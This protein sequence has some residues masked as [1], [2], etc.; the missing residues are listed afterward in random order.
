MRQILLVQVR[1]ATDPMID[2]EVS[3]I[4]RRFG[5]RAYHLNVR[6]AVVDAAKP[7]WL[8]GMDGLV[9]GGSGDFSVHH[10][11]SQRWVPA[12]RSVIERALERS[13]PGFGICFGHQLLGRHLGSEVRTEKSTS[14]MGTVMV[15]LTDSGRKSP[16][17]A[18]LSSPFPVHCG[19]SDYVVDVP[20]GVELLATNDVCHTQSFKVKD[21]PFFSVQFH[22]D[23]SG[24]D[25]RDRYLAYR[26]SFERKSQVDA[27][28]VAKTF[29]LDADQSTGLLGQFLDLIPAC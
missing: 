19:H 5:T 10:P 15:E 6:N 26:K 7:E 17:Y 2:H 3:C 27:T 1:A 23:M 25:A 9:I 20:P 14:E 21:R 18:G 29:R 16:L 11:K 4:R 12:L 8:N 22:P 24:K 13:V 28:E